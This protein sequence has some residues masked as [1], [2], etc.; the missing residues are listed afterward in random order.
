MANEQ[1]DPDAPTALGPAPVG[2]TPGTAWSLAEYPED[3]PPRFSPRAVTAVAV[4][5]SLVA[6]VAA[7]VLVGYKLNDVSRP[8][9]VAAPPSASSE[10]MVPARPPVVAPVPAPTTVT[11]VAQPP[12]GAPPLPSPPPPRRSGPST[13]TT[14]LAW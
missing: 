4:A 10:S 3:P 12:Q 1:V 6:I 2:D 5:V 9:D 7:A 13:Y 14:Y 8:A 11:V